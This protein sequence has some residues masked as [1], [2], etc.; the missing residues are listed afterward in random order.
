V[1]RTAE[2]R[3]VSG[4]LHGLGEVGRSRP[5]SE[6]LGYSQLSAN[7]DKEKSAQRTVESSPAIYPR[8]PMSL[9]DGVVRDPSLT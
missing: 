2:E 6:L 3:F 5:S 7:A 9:N 1:K 4:P 8:T